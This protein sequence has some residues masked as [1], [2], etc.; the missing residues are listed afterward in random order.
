MN[1]I[2][3][4]C[5]YEVEF[6]DTSQ[7]IECP[8]C[9][10]IA[11]EGKIIEARIALEKFHQEELRKAQ[12]ER[13]RIEAE[14]KQKKLEDNMCKFL[15][16]IKKIPIVTF[17]LIA[18]GIICVFSVFKGNES[19]VSSQLDII[20][21]N[22]KLLNCNNFLLR[23]NHNFKLLNFDIEKIILCNYD[24]WTERL[25]LYKINASDN[26]I[27]CVKRIWNYL[28]FLN[29][30]IMIM[31]DNINSNFLNLIHNL[32]VFTK[33]VKINISALKDYIHRK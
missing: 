22:I 29:I 33:Q 9:G 25:A 13:I 6:T 7:S 12:L 20:K 11:P 32:G 2:C 5:S 31:L 14:K 26:F 30:Y 23:L 19:S 18:V 3:D 21:E 4:V 1:W 8:C 27:L 15:F 24:I 17:M 16:L 10:T 28:N